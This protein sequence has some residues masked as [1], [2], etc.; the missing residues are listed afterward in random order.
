V[1]AAAE[2]ATTGA[3]R[4]REVEIG[5]RGHGLVGA[6]ETAGGLQRLLVES[7]G[8]VVRRFVSIHRAVARP[9]EVSDGCLPS[10]RAHGVEGEGI[11]VF[12]DARLVE[13][14]HRVHE[15]PMDEPAPVRR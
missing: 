3:P 14:F 6:W 9:T 5:G 15:A 11:H 1:S 13:T 4:Q 12:P 8:L 2:S 10:F 7:F